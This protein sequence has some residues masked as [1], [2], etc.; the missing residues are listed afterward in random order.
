M[1]LREPST[2]KQTRAHSLIL[3]TGIP[4]RE[5]DAE[6]LLHLEETQHKCAKAKAGKVVGFFTKT[7]VVIQLPAWVRMGLTPAPKGC[8][9]M[10]RCFA[11]CGTCSIFHIDALMT[12][13]VASW[14]WTQETNQS[15]FRIVPLKAGYRDTQLLQR[16]RAH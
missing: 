4:G 12:S 16:P 7:I 6:M 13:P 11:C 2:F 10:E 1:A 15:M 14:L 3:E 5:T 8:S 9:L